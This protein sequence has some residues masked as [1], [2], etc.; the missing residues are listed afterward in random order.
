MPYSKDNLKALPSS[1]KNLSIKQKNKFVEVF[2]ALEGDGME[3]S[4]AIPIALA[5]AKKVKTRKS[6]KMPFMKATNDEQ[7]LAIELVYEPYVPDAHGEW[8]SPET[9]RKACVDFNE[10]LEAGIVK[11]NLFHLANT[12]KVTIVKS[13]I[14]EVECQIGDFTIPEGS[15]LSSVQYNDPEL[16]ELKKS[17]VLKGVSVSAH[18]I[19]HEPIKGKE[20]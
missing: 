7:M 6:T 3:E 14:N 5:Q 17:G 12:D 16:W 8:M 9:I 4:M 10:K 18:G 13:W 15:W 1:T 19:V 20:E 2:N 11:P